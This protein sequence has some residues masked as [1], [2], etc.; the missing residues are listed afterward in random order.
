M[1]HL[2]IKASLSPCGGFLGK[3]VNSAFHVARKRSRSGGDG[4]VVLIP[5]KIFEDMNRKVI[6]TEFDFCAHST[7]VG[8]Q[9]YFVKVLSS[10]CTE[11]RCKRFVGIVGDAF[12]YLRGPTWRAY[13]TVGNVG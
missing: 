8:A 4:N 12:V 13:A 10:L 1:C 2:P 3:L 9:G 7:E 6:R 11:G 5:E